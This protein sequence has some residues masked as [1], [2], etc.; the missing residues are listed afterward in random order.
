MES[1]V[2]KTLR[3]A[4]IRFFDATAVT[5]LDY[6]FTIQDG[7][8]QYTP[9]KPDRIVVRDR[10]A[11]A[12]LRKGADPIGQI[13]FSIHFREFTNA[14]ADG[15]AID[16]LEERGAYA[17]RVSTAPS[18]IGTLP[19][20][21]STLSTS[22]SRS[23]APTPRRAPH[24]VNKGEA[25]IEIPLDGKKWEFRRPARAILRELLIANNTNH[26]RAQ[27]AAVGL[28]LIEVGTSKDEVGFYP[29]LS[30][31]ATG[32]CVLRYGGAIIDE[33]YRRRVPDASLSDAGT[34]CLLMVSDAF[35]LVPVPPTKEEIEAAEDFT[36]PPAVS[37]A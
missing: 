13:S 30:Y 2:V 31:L 23:T 28:C 33:A 7:S 24:R 17:A 11:I 1:E 20:A 34:E 6:T 3:D 8:Y 19:R 22:R 5:P 18:A 14:V 16:F 35:E 25:M 4:T 15:T 37:G 9:G 27:A 29:Q 12:G 21:T 36:D 32:C 26:G 10:H